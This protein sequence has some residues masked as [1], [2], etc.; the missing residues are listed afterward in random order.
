[1]INKKI[2]KLL[3]SVLGIALTI[4]FTQ[5]PVLAAENTQTTSV[6]SATSNLSAN[7]NYIVGSNNSYEKNGLKISIDSAIATKHKLKVVILIK[8]QTP[9]S[10]QISKFADIILSY[11]NNKSN[12][13]STSYRNIDDNTFMITMQKDTDKDVFPEKGPLRVD[14]VIPQ[15]KINAGIET[16]VDFTESFKNT[17]EKD[18]SINVPEIDST[19]K[20]LESNALG[21]QITYSTHE[22][23]SKD[24]LKEFSQ[25]ENARLILKAGSNIYELLPSGGSSVDGDKHDYIGTC[26]AQAATYD[27]I[28]NQNGLSVLPILC[29]M[30]DDER[31]QIYNDLNKSKDNKHDQLSKDMTDKVNYTKFFTFNDGTEGEIYNIDRT[32]NNL[33]VY[34]KGANELES[35]L[36]ASTMHIHYNLDE[37]LKTHDYYR[38]NSQINISKDP[39]DSLGYIVAFNDVDKDKTI[40]VTNEQMIKYVDKYKLGTEVQLTK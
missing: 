29:T 6:F 19:I 31:E 21:T 38:G 40:E 16:N 33:K 24:D 28:K 22:L 30:T 13:S 3:S 34:C 1:M 15:Y 7:K 39:K 18:L 32:D 26:N 9:I 23:D 5:M 8:G 36:L 11:G 25:V 20:K 35:L 14:I 37:A 17:I 4:G 10:N 12:R 27:K 2:N